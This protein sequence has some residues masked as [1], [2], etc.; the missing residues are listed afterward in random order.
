MSLRRGTTALVLIALPGLTAWASGPVMAQ[1]QAQAQPEKRTMNGPTASR[2]SAPEVAPVE[3]LGVR[4][5]QD[6]HDDRVG[7]QP[8]GHLAMI[9]A[10]TGQRLWRIK[11]YP[12]ADGRS[13]GK[14]TQARYFK[15][16]RLAS[17][18]AALEIAN[19]AGGVY[20][21]DLANRL[22][23]QVSG[24]ADS[25]AGSAPSSAPSKPLPKPAARQAHSLRWTGY[26]PGTRPAIPPPAR[27]VAIRWLHGSG[28]TS[29]LP[30]MPMPARSRPAKA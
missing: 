29:S 26:G 28:W 25:S 4:Y 22:A 15:S 17:D 9:E 8:G 10:K 30:T 1:A 27:V 23:T 2:P 13:T 19:E 7:D 5:L 24:P 11:V 3:H 18:G 14:P 20:R 16:M 21:V 12:V 6:T